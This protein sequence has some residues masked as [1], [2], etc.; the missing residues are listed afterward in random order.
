VL[1]VHHGGDLTG[2]HSDL[3]W[4]P[5]QNVG[6]VILTNAIPVGYFA[7]ASDAGCLRQGAPANNYPE[8]SCSSQ[9]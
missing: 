1:V 9:T 8:V 7:M 2:Y 4:L 3:S 6:L 5:Q